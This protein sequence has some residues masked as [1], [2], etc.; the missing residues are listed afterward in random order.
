MIEFENWRANTSYR[1][2]GYRNGN[3]FELSSNIPTI[4]LAGKVREEV[5]AL[6]SFFDNI[7]IEEYSTYLL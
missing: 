4:E 7:T 2:I 6:Y 5:V 1:L 3:K